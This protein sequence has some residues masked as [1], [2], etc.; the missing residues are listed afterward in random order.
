MMVCARRRV[1][2]DVV[3]GD[4][5]Y[6]C[7]LGRTGAGSA[8]AYKGVGLA[9]LLVM[10]C[11]GCL[12]GARDSCDPLAARVAHRR[13]HVGVLLFSFLRFLFPCVGDVG[14]FLV[15]LACW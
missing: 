3:A 6:D 15:R 11:V 13:D 10:L 4:V 5:A 8:R 1:V 7:A 2:C 14:L 12:C 9:L